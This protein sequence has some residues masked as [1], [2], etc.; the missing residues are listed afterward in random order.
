M[1]LTS[2]KALPVCQLDA[3]LSDFPACLARGELRYSCNGH[4]NQQTNKYIKGEVN[5]I[6]PQLLAVIFRRR[7]VGVMRGYT[8][9]HTQCPLDNQGSPSE[10]W[11]PRHQISQQRVQLMPNQLARR[12]CL[13]CVKR[14]FYRPR[15]RTT[16]SGKLAQDY[17]EGLR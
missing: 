6:E 1:S 14:R 2:A 16:Y 4:L 17:R 3:Y 11:R 8:V 7:D 5:L 13:P 10:L 9:H 15:A 12:A